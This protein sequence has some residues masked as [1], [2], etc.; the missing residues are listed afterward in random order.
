MNCPDRKQIGKGEKKVKRNPS[1]FTLDG[2]RYLIHLGIVE[3]SFLHTI[4][5]LSFFL[6]SYSWREMYKLMH[7]FFKVIV[8]L[9]PAY[10]YMI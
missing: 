6:V 2:G 7:V 1:S 8:I 9:Y 10:F 4:L 5:A 3:L